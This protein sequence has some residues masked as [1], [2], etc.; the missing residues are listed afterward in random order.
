[1]YGVPLGRIFSQ[2]RSD[3]HVVVAVRQD[4]YDGVFL[5][6]EGGMGE[7]EEEKATRTE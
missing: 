7:T 1:M 6:S 2:Q 5:G 3:G 4:D